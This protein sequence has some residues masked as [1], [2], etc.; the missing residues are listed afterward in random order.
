MAGDTGLFGDMKLIGEE[1]LDLAAI[2]IGDNY[3]MG[4]A[5]ALRAVEFLHP[6]VV[7]PIHYNTFP[8]IEQDVNAWAREV[9][10]KTSSKVAILTPGQSIEV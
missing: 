8:L 6:R 5:D 7:V 2:P 3:T 9:K 1:G 10:A 4:P